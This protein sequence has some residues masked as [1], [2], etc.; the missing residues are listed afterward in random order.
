MTSIYDYR[1][2]SGRVLPPMP[3]A[4]PAPYAQRMRDLM[5]KGLSPAQA[6]AQIERGDNH[7]GR[8]PDRKSV[9]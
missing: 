2:T 6:M 4:K 5:R 9:V 8:L 7:M 1:T 3:A